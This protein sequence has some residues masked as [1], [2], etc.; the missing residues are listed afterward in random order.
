LLGT[1]SDQPDPGVLEPA[2]GAEGL[3]PAP[4]EWRGRSLL[5]WTRLQAEPPADRRRRD[6]DGEELRASLAGWRSVDGDLAWWG[7]ALALLEER[8]A[9]PEVATRRRQLAGLQRP[10]ALLQWALDDGP[11][12]ALLRAW[13]PWKLLGALAGGG[14]D[15]SVRGLALALEP[16]TDGGLQAQVRLELGPGARS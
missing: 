11:A 16:D 9:G 3:I 2:L 6:G 1:R 4:L 15:P 12:L 13:Q 7:Q 8:G 10:D 14:L 5:V